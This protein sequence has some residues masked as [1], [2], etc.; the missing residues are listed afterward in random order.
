M[1]TDGASVQ[2]LPKLL[3][4]I[5]LLLQACSLQQIDEPTR[6]SSVRNE[7]VILLH[8]IVRT[9]R[10]MNKMQASLLA[11]GYKVA[12]WSYPSRKQSINVLAEEAI[13]DAIEACNDSSVRRINFVTHSMGGILVRYYLAK[14]EI[15]DLGRVV[16]LSPPNQGSEL[17]DLWSG[18]PGFELINGPAGY[19]LGTDEN[20]LPLQLGPANFEVGIITGNNTTNPFF[21][22]MIPGD[23]DGKVSVKSARLE[24]M[25]DFLVVPEAHSFIMRDEA[26]IQQLTHFLEHGR[27]NRSDDG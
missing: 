17:V 23:D 27:F 7:C 9:S 20:S 2:H 12:N 1:R 4:S 8:G 15:E 26:V 11:D 25:A 14:H 5:V 16:M 13:S 18:L 3:A 22:I 24:G 21:S 19:Q 10:S 6:Q